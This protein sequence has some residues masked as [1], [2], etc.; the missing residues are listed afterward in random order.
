[1]YER[2]A[3]AE[4]LT[5]SDGLMGASWKACWENCFGCSFGKRSWELCRIFHGSTVNHFAVNS[6]YS[7][8]NY[9][10][11]LPI[12][13][14]PTIRRMTDSWGQRHIIHGYLGNIVRGGEVSLS[15]FCTWHLN[16]KYIYI[17]ISD[18]FLY[19]YFVLSFPFPKTRA[20]KSWKEETLHSFIQEHT[21]LFLS[22]M[23]KVGLRYVHPCN[24]LCNRQDW[25]IKSKIHKSS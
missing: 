5:C 17:Y 6:D 10:S 20:R 22:F 16:L 12:W 9:S 15:F 4:G 1:M 14:S 19:S 25:F 24:P 18:P 3:Y 13:A 21:L 8:I 7:S 23:E 11:A 2:V